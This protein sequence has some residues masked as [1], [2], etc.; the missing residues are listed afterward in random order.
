MDEHTPN[1]PGEDD[2]CVAVIG[3]SCRFPGE[4][5]NAERFWELLCRGRS[6]H[7]KV[8]ADRFNVDAFHSGPAGGLNCS[9]TSAGHFLEEDISKWD[10]N[11]FGITPD[12]AAAMDPQQRLM[13]EVSYEAFENAGITPKELSES[14]TGCFCAS[15]S[16]DW[17]ETLFR[18][19]GAA[20]RDT[21]TGTGP[22]YIS[23]RVSWFFNMR[24]PCMTINTACSSSLVALHEAC[25]A[26]RSGECEMAIVGAANLIFNPEYYLFY[27][28]Q[29]FLSP[30]GRCKSF[31]AEGDGFGRGEGF[32]AVV[33][34][35]MSSAIESHDVIRAV[36]R[37]T[38]V[39][40]D[41]WTSGITLPNKYAQAELIRKTY[42]AAG[43]P[44]TETRYVEAH[45]TG[46]KVGD[47]AELE[48]IHSTLG[49]EAKTPILLGSVK[50]NIGHL[51][52]AAGIAGMIKSVLILEKGQ[53]P[54]T[55]GVQNLN[56]AINPKHFHVVD[57]LTSWPTGAGP[58]RIS[59]SSFGA[60]GTI[61]HAILEA[62]KCVKVNTTGFERKGDGRNDKRPST[63]RHQSRVVVLSAN[64][65]ST[66]K[67]QRQ[68]LSDHL[69][70]KSTPSRAT[71]P[72]RMSMQVSSV[73]ALREALG[74][75]N[76]PVHRAS[77]TKYR[78]GFIFTGQS[79]Q[80]PRMGVGLLTC[81]VFR[82]SVER[83]D[84]FLK[85]ALGCKW[86]ALEE[87]LLD[88]EHTHIHKAE[89]SQPLCTVLQVALIDLLDS[90]GITPVAMVGHS[91]GE[92]AAA[93]CVGALSAEDAWTAAYWRG[94]L[95]SRSRIPSGRML[96]AGISASEAHSFI[97][98]L[99]QGMAVVGCVNSPSSVTLSGDEKAIDELAGL[100]TAAGHFNRKLK[101]DV[102]YHSPH[103]SAVSHEYFVRI[104][105]IKPRPTRTDRVMYSSVTG[106]ATS[107]A[108]LGAKDWVRNLISPVLFSSAVESMM[109]SEQIDALL[110]IGPHSALAA[111]VKS[112]LSSLSP[113][114]GDK[115]YFSVLTRG[116]DGVETAMATAGELFTRGLEVDFAKVNNLDEASVPALLIDLPSYAWDHEKSFWAHSRWDRDYRLRPHP[117]YRFIGAPMP[118]LVANER[119]WRAFIKASEESWI[120]DHK[121]QGTIVYPAVG[122]VA[123]AIEA[124][125]QLATE[126]RAIRAFRLRDVRFLAA[127]E[128]NDSAATE[129]TLCVRQMQR[130]DD[131]WFS[132][133]ISSC[134]DGTS[135]K[136][137]CTGYISIDYAL[138]DET[139]KEARELAAH[140]D[141]IRLRFQRARNS[142]NRPAQ[143]DAFY[144]ELAR[145]GLEFGPAFRNIVDIR[146]GDGESFCLVDIVNPCGHR[147]GPGSQRPFIVHPA[148]F[149]P[150]TQ[151]I[152]AAAGLVSRTP[153]PTAIDELVIAESI[154]CHEGQQLA[155]YSHVQRRG[156]HT[157]LSDI[158]AL[159]PESQRPV[160]SLTGLKLAQIAGQPQLQDRAYN[161]VSRIQS[162]PALELTAPE[163]L[164]HVLGETSSA[165]NLDRS[166]KPLK[167]GAYDAV[168]LSQT[169][170]IK[171]SSLEKLLEEVKR[172][173]KPLGYLCAIGL[174]AQLEAALTKSGFHVHATVPGDSSDLIVTRPNPIGVAQF[175]ARDIIVL[176][177]PEPTSTCNALAE[178]VAK[179][180]EKQGY[181]PVR[182]AWP[183]PA[184][185]EPLLKRARCVS[186]VEV[187]K[188]LIADMHRETFAELQRV[189]TT[190][191]DVLWVTAGDDPSLYA[192]DG[193]ART[194]RNEDA[195]TRIRTLHFRSAQGSHVADVVSLAAMS[196]T[197]DNEFFVAEDGIAR[198]TRIEEDV[199]FT[200][201]I[202]GIE[203]QL[204]Q[205]DTI[206][207]T[208]NKSVHAEL[209]ED[210]LLVRVAFSGLNFKDIM[211]A[212][213]RV[214]GTMEGAEGSGSV[215]A[216]GK[217]VRDFSPGDQVL[218]L[219]IGM[220][221]SIARVKAASCRGLPDCLDLAEAASVPVVHC[222]A[223]NAFVRIAKAEAG[224]SVLIHAGA[225]GLGQVAIQYAKS[226]GMEVFVTVGSPAKRE[227]IQKMYDLPDDHILNSRDTSFGK[228][229]RRLTH[230][231]GVDMV[232]NSL[233]GE[234]LRESWASLAPGG[235]FVEVGKAVLESFQP[236]H[237]VGATYSTFDVEHII[238]DNPRLTTTLLDGALEFIRRGICKPAAPRTIF[239]V[240]RAQH[241]MRLM[242]TGQH[243]GK[244]LLSWPDDDVVSV[245]GD[246]GASAELRVDATYVLVGGLGGIG[247]SLA[248]LLVTL[249]ARHLCFLSRSGARSSAA[250]A[251]LQDLQCRGV[252]ARAYACDAAN[253]EQLEQTIAQCAKE[254]PPIHG[255]LQ[256]AAVFRDATFENLTFDDWQ[257]ATM[258]KIQASRNM[259]EVLPED[260]G[261]FV[262]LSSFAG[263]FGNLGQASYGAGSSYQDAL[264]HWRRTQGLKA[265]SLDL[266]IIKDVGV[267]AETGMTD[268][269]REW[270]CFGIGERQLHKLVRT[271]IQ[272]QVANINNIPPQVPTGIASARAALEAGIE[273]PFYLQDARFSRMAWTGDQNQ[274][275]DQQS[276]SV[277]FAKRLGAVKVAEEAE[278]IICEML[279]QRTAKCLAVSEDRID[280]DR[281]LPSYGINS[282]V[283]IEVRNWFFKESQLDVPIFDLISPLTIKALAEKIVKK[284]AL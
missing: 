233:S 265:V 89:F 3:L 22:E 73:E 278:Q 45:G 9:I 189:F 227:L 68:N 266:G 225:G 95:D 104:R 224:Q 111:P 205:L 180:L 51:E 75:E 228:A 149:D 53:I 241:A 252:N 61:S 137:N 63:A 177:S 120:I 156:H 163:R 211:I 237:A 1:R 74:T 24:G 62:A 280:I 244:L 272:D 105:G 183:P 208:E 251:L 14:G 33:L 79:A 258:P 5:S 277:P 136:L 176:E 135:L 21:W 168:L 222:T 247:R 46:T 36:V 269:L 127:A 7:S 15:N 70:S 52:G 159:D 69:R 102:A 148:T 35:R 41:G 202:E 80:W 30:S 31:D 204:C 185:Y 108:G 145:I 199:P 158:H 144:A 17:R 209:Q 217:G 249:G 220:H 264:A 6:A 42:A 201:R 124:A 260:I 279:V 60:S 97:S 248:E 18:D 38:G 101:T 236:H 96:A 19:P 81:S 169:G 182:V 255:A 48:A 50:T 197:K 100:L 219:S 12:E 32:G 259:Q 268:N 218:C 283:A 49:T 94:N 27:S 86:S 200:D 4:A 232:L 226:F 164:P 114:Q 56:P 85:T 166:A 139:G 13:M 181:R 10:A 213:G 98:E 28:N 256:C 152:M 162:E 106:R 43:L 146:M 174:A 194:I 112:T 16:N 90:W 257:A 234:M 215:I 184:S 262:M 238:R 147:D 125:R 186:L 25:R 157:F 83:A 103:L 214:A 91:S 59:I 273:P 188:P 123:M 223:Y 261:F 263:L 93:Y 212:M 34:K 128:M 47:P 2:H 55:I 230:G 65:P 72:Y 132:F 245:M 195:A 167:P 76:V 107:A 172:L 58:M 165:S 231:R 109:G 141:E 88:D 210:E 67:R 23:G 140:E 129:M 246:G 281:S 142:C 242:Q 198:S 153:I 57:E 150:I 254:M 240:S 175:Q 271:A 187:T 191:S 154:P 179:Q 170:V 113:P 122:Y 267:L 190:A 29:N 82:K 39:G 275:Q 121:I 20:P 115:D 216:T 253:R 193:M 11:F 274:G 126:N 155:V 151:T 71:H 78:L 250:Q 282:L 239:P 130:D 116:K 192:I 243:T 206:H 37:G 235:T 119:I 64:D 131:K 178:E 173:L 117:A 270:A 84:Q 160:L 77:S 284:L 87:L 133:S 203:T 99:R 54:P 118:Q 161:V 26:I 66:L 92:I 110:E 143:P 207:L 171:A 8:P 221:S 229:I 134:S 40:Q 44:M 196:E 138:G 276:G